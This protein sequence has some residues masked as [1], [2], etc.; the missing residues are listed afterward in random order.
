MRIIISGSREF[1][2]Y[3]IFN[4]NVLNI[5]SEIQYK[6]E[7]NPNDFEIIH[8][9][10][11]GTDK[12]GNKFADEYQL[13]KK[14]FEADWHNFEPPVFVKHNDFFGDYNAL[15]GRNRN[16]KM[17]DYARFDNPI[18]IAFWQNNS[19]GT[20]DMIDIAKRGSVPLFVHIIKMGMVDKI[21]KNNMDKL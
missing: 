2:N 15:A 7:I 11:Y 5:F 10:A 16:M 12:L 17:F 20:K 6:K 9:G 21:I 18:L 1:E 14:I 4:T 13:K 8:G 3:H 19:K